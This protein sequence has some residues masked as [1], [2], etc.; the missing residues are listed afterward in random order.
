MRVRSRAAS[1]LV[2]ANFLRR[3][4]QGSATN[5]APGSC[6]TR[7]FSNRTNSQLPYCH[8]TNVNVH[9]NYITFNSSTGDELFSATP[10]GAGGISFCTGSDFYKFNFNWVCGNLSTGDGGG[11]GHLGFSYNGDI[12][13]NM[14]LFNQSTN[15]TIPTNGGAMVIQGAPDVDPTCGAT[16][17]QDCVVIPAGS[18]GPS[19]GTGPG[20]VI[21][22]NMMIGNQAESGSG[23]G[24]ALQQVNGSDVVA[25]PNSS[26]DASLTNN[27]CRWNSVQVTNNIIVNNVAGWDGGGIS[28]LDSLAVNII[29]NTIMHNDSTASSGVLFNTI[30]APLASTQGS[31]CTNAAATASC[32]QVAGLVSIQNSAVLSANLAANTVCPTSHG[33]NNATSTSNCIKTSVPLLDNDVITQNRSYYIGV[34]A[35][36]AGVTNQQNQVALY[37]AFTTTLAPSQI[38]TGACPACSYLG[39]RRPW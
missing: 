9:N 22:A 19:D 15:P 16:T 39:Y 38:S 10:A 29:N 34:S 36:A 4:I 33:V 17:D 37:N 2:R 7:S 14:F 8:D 6:Q 1:T 11:L 13:H 31:N 3:I 32:P 26:C 28:L 30:G 18:V 20:L 25:F 27:G 12:E 5:A 21:N 23:G 35:P 24:I